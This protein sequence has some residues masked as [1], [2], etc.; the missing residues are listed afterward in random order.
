MH[1][2]H[3]HTI[4]ILQRSFITG[5][6]QQM[7]E[8]K[9]T[10]TVLVLGSHGKIGH[11]SA[12]AFADA[13]WVVRHYQRGT[14][15]AAVA[16]G[17]D[18]IV[19]GLNPPNYHNWAKLIPEIT[20][21][22]IAAAKASGATVILPG[23]V[24]NFGDTGGVWSEETP[25]R[26]VSRKGHIRMQMEARYRESGI[27]TIVLRA[28]NFIDPEGNGDI[29]QLFLLRHIAKGRIIIGGGADVMQA[30][31]YVPDWAQAALALAEKRTRLDRFEDVPF[32][33]HSFTIN[34]LK[35]CLEAYLGRPLTLSRFPWGLM[36]LASPFW[37]LAR[38]LSEMRYL[39]ETPHQLS[40]EKF[41]KL[42]P[43]FEAETLE[44]VMLSG[45]PAA[46]RQVNPGSVQPVGANQA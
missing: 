41:D 27:P 30:W 40:R 39:W 22:V 25:Q 18:V 29:M 14:D 45:L 5:L 17:A 43:G 16:L 7:I 42:L 24:Y 28:G 36:R 35:S 20:E 12:T 32:P 9:M 13:G 2:L 46:M 19:N 23:N 44:R 31:C 37:E 34:E 15:M 1:V 10:G 26:P 6:I 38:E 21:Q 11:H 4:P 8:G 33:G 3:F